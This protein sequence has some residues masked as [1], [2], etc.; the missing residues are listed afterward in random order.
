MRCAPGRKPPPDAPKCRVLVIDTGVRHP[1]PNAGPVAPFE[2]CLAHAW[3]EAGASR[4]LPDGNDDQFL[5]PAAGHGTFIA[6]LYGRLAPGTI[7]TVAKEMG[8]FGDIDDADAARA[9]ARAAARV[10]DGPLIVSM[11]FRGFTEA[12]DPPIALAW[13]IR[14][15]RRTRR[16][17]GSVALVASCGNDASCRPTWPAVLRGVIG[18]AALGV[19]NPAPFT[20]FGPNARACAPGV[21]IISTF[22][23]DLDPG[24]KKWT[25]NSC[26]DLA[27]FQGWASW[28]GTSF[29]APIVGA[30]LAWEA[31]TSGQDLREIVRRRIDD[32]G[33]TRI[34]GLGTIINVC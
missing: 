32:P 33:L 30:E 2:H 15:L 4:E 13:A 26:S 31:M 10:D 18:V 12:D 25:A 28:S 21:D 23:F 27:D 22:L 17:A 34:A 29:S 5:D 7:V 9:I 24:R 8:T 19:E 1:Q 11:S 6:G 3:P 20:N 16:T 14:L